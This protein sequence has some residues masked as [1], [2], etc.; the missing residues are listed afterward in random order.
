MD[1]YLEGEVKEMIEIFVN[2]GFSEEDAT[3]V[4]AVEE[5]LS[6]SII[7]P[8]LPVAVPNK[9]RLNAPPTLPALDSGRLSDPL[10][11]RKGDPHDG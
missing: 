6:A 1:N 5:T 8:V 2:K 11:L 4:T 10:S 9:L 3:T 7:A